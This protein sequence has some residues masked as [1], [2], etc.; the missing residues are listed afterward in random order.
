MV[1]FCFAYC[2][3]A[4]QYK[5]TTSLKVVVATSLNVIVAAASSWCFLVVCEGSVRPY[6]E[7]QI[8]NHKKGDMIIC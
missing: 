5:A 3:S 2:G 7:F 1:R 4:V 8:L 6:S